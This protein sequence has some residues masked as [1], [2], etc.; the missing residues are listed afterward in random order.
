MIGTFKKFVWIFKTQ[1]NTTEFTE[2]HKIKLFGARQE[3]EKTV[4][5]HTTG[6]AYERKENELIK[7]I[8]L[9]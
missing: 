7:L 1:Y 3:M 6:V 8:F 2:I 5:F 4:P 9:K